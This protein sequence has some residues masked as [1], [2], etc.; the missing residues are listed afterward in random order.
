M[1]TIAD[2]LEYSNAFIHAADNLE[3][4]FAVNKAV[5]CSNWPVTVTVTVIAAISVQFI[6]V[7]F[8][9]VVV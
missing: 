1:A 3:W 5:V 4:P 8:E 7:I 2:Y 9:H 6:H